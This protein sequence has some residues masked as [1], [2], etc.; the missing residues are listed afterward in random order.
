MKNEYSVDHDVVTIYHKRRSGEVIESYVSVEDLPRLLAFS[1]SWVVCEKAN[2][3]MYV[4]CRK[5]KTTLK[6][7]RFLTDAEDGDIVDHKDRNSLNNCRDNII[8]TTQT[9]NMRNTSIRKDNSS[10]H[11]GVC[12]YSRNGKWKA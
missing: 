4:V 2:G 10:G 7:H 9:E 11:K 6:L 12:Y 8:K 1:V 3:S 5:G